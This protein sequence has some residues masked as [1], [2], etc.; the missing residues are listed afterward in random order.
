MPFVTNFLERG[1]DRAQVLRPRASARSV[2]SESCHATPHTLLS[3]HSHTRSG[4][5]RPFHT[6][7]CRG[8]GSCICARW[9]DHRGDWNTSGTGSRPD[10]ID[11]SWDG[12]VAIGLSPDHGR[13]S[14][15][16][17]VVHPAEPH[18]LGLIMRYA[19]RSMTLAVVYVSRLALLAL[20]GRRLAQQGHTYRQGLRYEGATVPVSLPKFLV[21]SSGMLLA[22]GRADPPN[23]L[24]PAGKLAAFRL[25][26]RTLFP[27]E[28]PGRYRL[29]ITFDDP[30]SRDGS[31]G[32]AAANFTVFAR[33]AG[34]TPR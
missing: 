13:V 17:H 19:P 14:L 24:A 22:H 1:S 4:I 3:E 10:L 16:L 7:A 32:E 11:W 20:T 28:L 5:P 23:L 9:R 12:S 34:Q 33:D 15:V 25:D 6:L 31:S 18:F 30:K 27:I 26:L 2:R 21:R 8:H 29:E